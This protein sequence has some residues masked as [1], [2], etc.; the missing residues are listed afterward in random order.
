LS[1]EGG[2]KSVESFINDGKVDEVDK[3]T[4]FNEWCAKE[5]VIMP[6]LEYPAYFEGGLLGMRCKEDIYHRE[7][8]I[9]VPV[10]MT[11]SL[12]KAY[13]H[14]VLSKIID[15]NPEC[16]DKDTNADWE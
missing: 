8:Y 2:L 5:G 7:A 1:S 10:K 14:P 6:K 4:M 15:E 12:D 11:V 13:S 3:F 9:M 16:F